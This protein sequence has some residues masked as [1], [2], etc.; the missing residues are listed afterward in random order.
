MV[1]VLDVVVAYV[2][3]IVAVQRQRT[4]PTNIISGVQSGDSPGPIPI[5]IL[6]IAIRIVVVA[7]VGVIV[8]VQRQRQWIPHISSRV[9]GR[10]RPVNS[11]QMSILESMIGIV[12]VTY[13]WRIIAI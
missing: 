9:H 4:T 6:Q 2:G 1:D 5:G 13:V 8:A 11:I 12:I 10:N 3:V 7:Y